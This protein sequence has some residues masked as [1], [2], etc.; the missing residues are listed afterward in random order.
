MP[1][2][3]L[4]SHCDFDGGCL[5]ERKPLYSEKYDSVPDFSESVLWGV[6]FVSSMPCAQLPI[7]SSAEHSTITVDY[8][9]YSNHSNVTTEPPSQYMQCIATEIL[10]DKRTFHAHCLW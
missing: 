7:S 4:H 8:S 1:L 10:E 6:G 3:Q 2:R 5:R 9:K